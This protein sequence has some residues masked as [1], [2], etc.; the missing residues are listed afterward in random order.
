MTDKANLPDAARQAL[1]VL[2]AMDRR[3]ELI[4]RAILL[5]GRGILAGED[6]YPYYSA[7]GRPYVWSDGERFTAQAYNARL[8]REALEAMRGAS[9]ASSSSPDPLPLVLWRMP[10]KPTPGFYYTDERGRMWAT[11]TG[12]AGVA[13]SQCGAVIERGYMA[14]E[15]VIDPAAYLCAAHVA[16]YDSAT[17]AGNGGKPSAPPETLEDDTGEPDGEA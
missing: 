8:Q 7:D 12:G 3:R 9:G 10:G 17:Y 4:P 11:F 13:C 5:L 16:T 14:P 6:V 1:D 2:E 15:T